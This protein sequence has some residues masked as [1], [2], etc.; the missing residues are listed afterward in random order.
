MDLKWHNRIVNEFDLRLFVTIMLGLFILGVGSL[1]SFGY[2][3]MDVVG[4]VN[5]INIKR[6]PNF[7]S[8]AFLLTGGSSNPQTIEEIEYETKRLNWLCGGVK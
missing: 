4:E 7:N 2:F 5:N 6:C 3:D 1:Y 8:K